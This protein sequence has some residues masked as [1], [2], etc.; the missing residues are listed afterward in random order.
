MALNDKIG[1][2]D[3]IDSEDNPLEIVA[4]EPQ[5]APAE[6]PEERSDAQRLRDDD[7]E[8][9]VESG[10]DDI[11]VSPH[12]VWKPKKEEGEEEEEESSEE[13]EE[14]KE[15]TSEEEESEEQEE[16]KEAK[17]AEKKKPVDPVQ[18]R[19]N[20][21][22]RE[23]YDA[24]REAEKLARELADLKRQ[25]RELEYDKK[26]SSIAMEKPKEEDFDTDA[27]YYEALGRW[28]ARVELHEAQHIPPAEEE[29][30]S[31]DTPE[32]LEE[33]RNRIIAEGKETYPDFEEL[34]LDDNLP[35]SPIMVEA[36]FDSK[37]AP[38]IFYLLAQSPDRAAEIAKMRSPA[39][40]A[41][42]IGR[43]ESEFIDNEVEEVVSHDPSMDDESIERS[44]P[45]KKKKKETAPPPVKPIGGGGKVKK[46]LDE[47]S[48]ADYY[49][50]RGFDRTGFKKSRIP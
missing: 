15:E 11:E 24:K 47:M 30:G 39:Q 45:K 5:E 20:K 9:E 16:E 50:A 33:A 38:D 22:T 29:A 32:T 7:P 31:K 35:I 4:Y 42:E 23:K 25:M 48:L 26:K 34:V 41:R 21:I 13:E 17:P 12:S 44:K 10:D 46:N 1:E 2:N 8:I 6:R 49:E 43:I 3:L 36:A 18:K 28:G 19:I 40:V 37:Y 14:E 27:E